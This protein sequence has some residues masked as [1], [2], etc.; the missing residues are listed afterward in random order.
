MVM[1]ARLYDAGFW[2]FVLIDVKFQTFDLTLAGN[3]QECLFLHKDTSYTLLAPKSCFNL[4]NN[5]VGN[6]PS[7]QLG[8]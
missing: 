2:Y 7:S 8:I 6:P 5:L 3:H 1:P 4:L